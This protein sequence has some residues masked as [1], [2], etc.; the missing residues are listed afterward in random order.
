VASPDVRSS[1]SDTAPAVELRGDVPRA[2]V[3]VLDAVSGHRRINRFALVLEIL[4]GWADDKMREVTA[5]CRVT[6]T[7]KD[8]R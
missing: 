5:I 4:E 6:G 8:E 2:L 3:D 1:R 7:M